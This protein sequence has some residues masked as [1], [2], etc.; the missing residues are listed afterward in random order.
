[1]C[2]IQ[3]LSTINSLSLGIGALFRECLEELLMIETAVLC[4]NSTS[5]KRKR[6]AST[7]ASQNSHPTITFVAKRSTML[8]FT[9]A[10]GQFPTLITGAIVPEI[11]TTRLFVS[12][13]SMCF[14]GGWMSCR[15]SVDTTAA[16]INLDQAPVFIRLKYCSKARRVDSEYVSIF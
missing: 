9:V 3:L 15:S 7:W 4:V 8:K 6:M 1:M 14:L 2:D 5:R 10:E 16:F 12:R 13:T 11:L